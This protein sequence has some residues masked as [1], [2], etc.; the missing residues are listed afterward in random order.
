MLRP[1]YLDI[2][3]IHIRSSV[4]LHGRIVPLDKIPYIDNPELRFNKHE[5]TELPYRY[6]KD[7]NG[8]AIMPEV[9]CALSLP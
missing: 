1:G 9:R 2:G 4:D 7:S 6:V 5:S 8:R 3:K